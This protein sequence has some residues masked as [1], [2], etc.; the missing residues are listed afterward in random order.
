MWLGKWEEEVWE[1]MGWSIDMV[2]E[3]Y[4]P[5]SIFL[6]SVSAIKRQVS[7]EFMQCTRHRRTEVG[8]SR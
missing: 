2:Y 7:G 3:R 6:I 4:L 1:K 8:T 5:S